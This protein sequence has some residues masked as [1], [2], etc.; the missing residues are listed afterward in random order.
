MSVLTIVPNASVSRS[1]SPATDDTTARA[2]SGAPPEKL[3]PGLATIESTD[4]SDRPGV[5]VSTKRAPGVVPSGTATTTSYTSRSPMTTSVPA[6]MAS[7]SLVATRRLSTSGNT[8]RID[9]GSVGSTA[10]KSRP[11]SRDA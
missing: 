4:T 8:V 5:R 6:V 10:V 2:G 9:A 11:P 1:A 7:G 3:R